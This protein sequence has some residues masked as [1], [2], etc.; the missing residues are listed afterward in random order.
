MLVIASSL[1]TT[2][3]RVA[4]SSEVALRLL[5]ERCGYGMAVERTAIARRGGQQI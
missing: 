2:G 5:T 3:L 1:V 4:G